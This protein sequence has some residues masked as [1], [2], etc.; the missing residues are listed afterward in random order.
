MAYKMLASSTTISFTEGILNKKRFITILTEN[1][2]KMIY[3]LSYFIYYI[4]ITIL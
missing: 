2:E 3:P 4:L 1:L